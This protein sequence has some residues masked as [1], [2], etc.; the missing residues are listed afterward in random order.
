MRRLRS[1]CR[2]CGCREG[3]R[4]SIDVQTQAQAKLEEL[5]VRF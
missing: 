4:M 1:A 5:I 3:K 2:P